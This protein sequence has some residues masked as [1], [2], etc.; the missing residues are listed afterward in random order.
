MAEKGLTNFFETYLKKE[1]IFK[2]K[3]VFQSNYVPRI[4]H[5]RKKEIET[6]S[7]ILAPSLKME[8]PSNLFVYGK[9]GT[10]KTLTVRYVA[11]KLEEVAKRNNIALM[12]I[13]KNCK[14]KR[15]ADTEYR[16]MT[17]LAKCFNED[18]PSTGLSTRDVYD[19]FIESLD[20]EKRIAI[21]I[22]DEIDELVKESD[23]VLYTLLRINTELKNSQISIVGISNNWT[24][25]DGLDPRIKSSL[26]QEEL[27]FPPYN[28]LQLQSILKQR[29]KLAFKP[30]AVGEG[31]IE[32][33]AA[34]AAREHG[35]ARR[36]LELL[37]IA[38]EIA[39]R[40]GYEKIEIKHLDE[41]Q[42]KL[43]KDRIMDIVSGLTKH[44]QLVLY[45]ILAAHEQAK[46]KKP[47]FTGDI[48]EFYKKLCFKI[49]E[50][51]LTQRRVSDIIAEHDM[52]GL[53]N[54]KVISYGRYGRTREI[55]LAVSKSQTNNIKETLKEGLNL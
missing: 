29:A 30:N 5:H 45:S 26:S 54:A 42:E 23:E 17:E 8:K 41:A 15:V 39:E 22:L 6:I 12:I 19:I 32:K 25:L 46:E 37:R 21:L 36:A 3:K 48:Y 4:I 40:K 35:D 2:N 14:L 10:G 50:R 16:L 51:P 33:C 28:A 47:V 24:F 44:S 49:R 27:M 13:Y 31:V 11:E 9:P 43:E 7:T 52:C 18:V 53:I 20:K 34:Y 38:G 55:C 1:P